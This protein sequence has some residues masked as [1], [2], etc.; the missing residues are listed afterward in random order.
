[1]EQLGVEPKLLFAQIVNFTIII[2]V[3]TKLLYKPILSMLQ[4]RREEIEAGLALTEKLRLEEEKL[5]AKREKIVASAHAEASAI[6]DEA[7]K[8]AKEVEA[9]IT[10]LAHKQAG[11]IIA[12][13]RSEVER[14]REEALK[15]AQVAAVTL[16]ALMAKRL[17]SSVLGAKEQRLVTGKHLK[18]LATFAKKSANSL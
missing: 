15:E 1:M 4:K 16:A 2:V 8:Q 12:K 18:E 10:A 6:I 17:L 14:L 3:L 7:K 5:V 11:E 9:D 13:G